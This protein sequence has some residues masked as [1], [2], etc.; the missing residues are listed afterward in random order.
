MEQVSLLATAVGSYRFQKLVRVAKV[1]SRILPL[2]HIKDRSGKLHGLIL[3]T[4]VLLRLAVM[5]VRSRCG[6]KTTSAAMK[7]WFSKRTSGLQSTAL[8]GPHGSMAWCWQQELQRDEFA[9]SKKATMM[10]GKKIHDFAGHKEG[11]N[12]L[13]WGPSTEP[14][15]LTKKEGK[16]TLPPKRLVSGGNDLAV[17]LW[18]LN[19]GEE[20]P[21]NTTIGEHK[22]WVR[23]VAWCNN[24]GLMHDMIAT[25][26]EDKTCKV[27]KNTGE[28]EGVTSTKWSCKEI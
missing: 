13:S 23:D 21:K 17:R 15:L 11:V 24:I 4:K 12:G 9:F 3:N 26:S 22:D 14:A 28:S 18:E 2:K 10:N 5:I 16:F 19:D 20:E 25:C 7:I 8:P 6:S 1:C 27:W